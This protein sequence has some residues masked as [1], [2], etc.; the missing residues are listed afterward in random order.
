M[1]RKGYGDASGA[2]TKACRVPDLRLQGVPELGV[3]V[4]GQQGEQLCEVQRSAKV[5]SDRDGT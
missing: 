1:H 3:A 4:G 2:P 5:P